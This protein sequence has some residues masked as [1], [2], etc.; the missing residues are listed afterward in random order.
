[1]AILVILGPQ[2]SS[3]HLRLILSNR[4]Y[5]LSDS[6]LVV[7]WVAQL[8]VQ[9]SFSLDQGAIYDK[10]CNR[11]SHPLFSINISLAVA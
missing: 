10:F 4:V 6:V 2:T 5:H 9:L 3:D 8:V 11:L 1:L 7:H